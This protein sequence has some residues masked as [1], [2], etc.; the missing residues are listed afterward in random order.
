MDLA[1]WAIG[2]VLPKLEELCKDEYE[3]SK[4]AR[5]DIFVL[6]SEMESLNAALIKVSEVPLDQLDPMVKLWAC[7]VRE[8]SYGLEDV[9]DSVVVNLEVSKPA[10]PTNFLAS[11]KKATNRV[12]KLK[13][14]R[15]IA[16]AIKD[17]RAE[18]RSIVERRQRYNLDAAIAP[19]SASP[20]VD[21]R[22]MALYQNHDIIGI[23][24]SS[25][26]LIKK[27]TRQDDN[28]S[29]QQLKILSIFGFTGL[30]KTTLAKV[31]YD[32]VKAN[33]EC[34][35]FVQVGHQPDLKR[36]LK[37]LLFEVGAKRYQDF[38][39]LN[40]MQLID[41]VR[42]QLHQKRYE[43]HTPLGFFEHTCHLSISKK[44]AHIQKIVNH[45]MFACTLP[46][47]RAYIIFMQ[48]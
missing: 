5:Q 32:K 9:I 25:E 19:Y 41:A 37:D 21:P 48:F 47:L 24:E 15:E 13:A 4:G 16:N 43:P 3:L 29:K 38:S 12:K 1:T 18:V 11:V 20:T 22:L 34:W 46:N 10:N 14:R 8:L 26:D 40:E 45:E 35:A 36:T 39:K 6:H 42:T 30:G 33:F 23:E 17:I 31:V 2:S 27:I 44:R 7:E 28:F